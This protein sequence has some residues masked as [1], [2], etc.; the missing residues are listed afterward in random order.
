MKE[1]LIITYYESSPESPLYLK[2]T[3][4]T[5]HKEDFYLIL[6]SHTPIP[7]GI[8]AM[9][10]WC[11]YEKLNV[12]EDRRYS[13]GVA[14]S[15]LLEHS[16]KHLREQGINWTFKMS[17]DVELVDLNQIWA[18][19][20]EMR[21]ELVTCEWGESWVGTNSFYANVGFLLDN[22]RFF[23][24]VD[25]MFAT[26]TL[27]E[28]CWKWDLERKGLR[29]KC[30]SYPHQTVMFGDN[31][32]DVLWYDYGRT[33]FTYREDKFWI[34]RSEELQARVAIY[35]YHTDLCLFSEELLIGANPTWIVPYKDVHLL[36]ENGFYVE[37]GDRPEVRYTKV[38]DFRL[39][40]P[41]S[42]KWSMLKGRPDSPAFHE[43]MRYALE[44]ER[45]R[46]Q[47]P[48]GLASARKLMFGQATEIVEPDPERRELMSKA[49]GPNSLVKITDR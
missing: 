46:D 14:E 1:G 36:A 48:W 15:N 8:Q 11:F 21:Y 2:K 49:Y 5:L 30:F 18:W 41:L 45:E 37:I 47:S 17:Y 12:V 7:E 16:L 13:H 10:D 6:A 43:F 24:T 23:R 31:K 3:I 39:K 25:E 28:N 40:H 29:A 44:P 26:N 22:V 27:L 19:R 42:K 9:C 34:S 35:D 4:E 32:I 33:E 20:Q 38:R